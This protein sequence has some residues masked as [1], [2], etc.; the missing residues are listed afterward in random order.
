MY[1]TKSIEINEEVHTRRRSAHT[2]TPHSHST[3]HTHART[4]APHARTTHALWYTRLPARPPADTHSPTTHARSHTD[5]PAVCQGVLPSSSSRSGQRRAH[6]RTPPPAPYTH[7]H[8]HIRIRT[9]PHPHIYT[10]ALDALTDPSMRIGL[11]S[12]ASCWNYVLARVPPH[13]VCMRE[14]VCEC[15]CVGLCVCGGGSMVYV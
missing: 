7:T 15:V 12:N 14:C 13:Q 8:I 3:W 9:P 5:C 4:L 6:A 10:Q 2:V 1:R 11:W